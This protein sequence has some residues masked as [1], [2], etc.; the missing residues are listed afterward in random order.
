MVEPDSWQVIPHP[1]TGEALNLRLAPG[2]LL[3]EVIDKLKGRERGYAQWRRAAEDEILR[4]MDEAGK[5]IDIIGDLEVR[6]RNNN[7]AHWDPDDT[8]ATLNDLTAR[9]LIAPRFAEGVIVRTIT[10]NRSA[11]NKL[12]E[13]LAPDSEAYRE[14][15]RCRTWRRRSRRTIETAVVPDLEDALPKLDQGT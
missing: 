4:R 8:E 10:V 3:L 5:K 13:S 12:L 14:L 6:V 15:V 2:E 9:G 7:E 1:E 11:I